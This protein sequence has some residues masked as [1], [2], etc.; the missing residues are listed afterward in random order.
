MRTSRH[1]NPKT[2]RIFLSSDNDQR[3]L[4]DFADALARDAFQSQLFQNNVPVN[5]HIDRWERSVPG[6]NLPGTDGNAVFV[7]RARAAGVVLCI[8]G[9]HLRSGTREELEAVL[10]DDE[11]DVA[12]I[13]CVG[14][15]TWPD[16]DVGRF[17]NGHRETIFIDRAGLPDSSGPMIAITRF[18]LGHVLKLSQSLENNG[19]TIHH[20]DR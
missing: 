7:E 8:L 5:L 17:L 16:D 11:V 9:E 20:E 6:K 12:I 2:V 1:T 15:D 4:R 14:E 13:W 19:G 3:P 10:R 18:L